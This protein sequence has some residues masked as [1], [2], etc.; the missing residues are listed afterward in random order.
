MLPCLAHLCSHVVG[1]SVH[2]FGARHAGPDR[3]CQ[4]CIE[5]FCPHGTCPCSRLSDPSS[6]IPCRRSPTSHSVDGEVRVGEERDTVA[7]ATAAVGHNCVE[8]SVGS[9]VT[10]ATT[11][12]QV[13][14]KKQSATKSKQCVSCAMPSFP[15]PLLLLLWR[16]HINCRPAEQ[17][18][19]LS[20]SMS[21]PEQKFSTDIDALVPRSVS[22]PLTFCTLPNTLRLL[23]HLKTR[24]SSPGCGRFHVQKCTPGSKWC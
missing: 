20:V 3:A 1:N 22:L 6:T 11:R 8:V 15:R 4:C 18:Q 24:A 12:A 7:A 23:R 17:M 5:L 21:P 9:Q 2:T 16:M 14:N 19:A 13:R 10:P